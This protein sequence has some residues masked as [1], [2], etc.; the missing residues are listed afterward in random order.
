M[1]STRI[2]TLQTQSEAMLSQLR[3]LNDGPTFNIDRATG[4]ISVGANTELDYEGT[5]P[6]MLPPR[7]NSD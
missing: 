5:V 1:R 3:C 4:Q 2:T 7:G 6:R